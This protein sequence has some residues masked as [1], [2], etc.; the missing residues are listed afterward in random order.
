MT[1][2][3]MYRG[4]DRVLTITASEALTGSQI[5]FTA[6]RRPGG[7]I[8][9]SKTTDAGITI[10]EPATTAVIALDAAD[11]RDLDPCVLRWDIEVV[12][13]TEK[14]H[15]VASGQLNIR[16]DITHPA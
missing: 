4:D 8:V 2:L 15:T 9:I 13:V 1:D 12:D 16:A 10:G 6:R 14:T 7:A 3:S 11:T 5:T